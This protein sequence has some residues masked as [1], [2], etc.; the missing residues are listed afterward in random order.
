MFD[1]IRGSQ[2]A[3]TQ[4]HTKSSAVAQ[5]DTGRT[6]KQFWSDKIFESAS[7]FR[8]DTR[9]AW[10]IINWTSP[11]P[12]R[13]TESSS[14]WAKDT[15]FKF[16]QHASGAFA[17]IGVLFVGAGASALG[18]A[19]F[20]GNGMQGALSGAVLGISTVSAVAFWRI[21]KWCHTARFGST[22]AAA[23]GQ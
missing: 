21:A 22:E 11:N 23:S 4:P 10:D 12:E 17:A 9:K 8:E 20:V 3:V 5:P 18:E 19:L 16:A 6:Y 14:I 15:I 1:Q 13:S 7:S 2:P